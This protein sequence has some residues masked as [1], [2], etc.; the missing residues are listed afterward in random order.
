MARV[1]VRDSRPAGVLALATLLPLG[2]T[3]FLPAGRAAQ[4]EPAKSAPTT[5]GDPAEVVKLIDQS[6]R[7][8]WSENKL[9]PA[10][11]CD[12]YEFIRRASLDIIGRIATPAEIKTYLDDPV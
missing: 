5:G 4:K 7:A 6:L 8:A 9:T 11:R 12:D 2:G 1:G 3:L 10:P